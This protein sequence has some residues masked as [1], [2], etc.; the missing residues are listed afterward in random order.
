MSKM[1]EGEEFIDKLSH[2]LRSLVDQSNEPLR[3]FLLAILIF[4]QK[5]AG[6]AFN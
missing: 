3:P 5:Y 4:T 1:G 6:K 2:S